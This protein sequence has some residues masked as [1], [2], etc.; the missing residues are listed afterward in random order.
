VPVSRDPKVGR[1]EAC[2]CGSGKKYKQCCESKGP[3]MSGSTRLI[4][5]AI[6]GLVAAGLV[7]A[8]TQASRDDGGVQRVWSPEHG[9]YHDVR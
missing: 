1:N 7:L 8:V 4:L 3:R 5:L 6:A 9:H 2:P